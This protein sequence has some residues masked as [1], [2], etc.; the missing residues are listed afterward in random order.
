MFEKIVEFAKKPVVLLVSGTAVGSVVGYR[1]GKYFGKKAA[2]KK[3]E[4]SNVVVKPQQ[5]E[6]APGDGEQSGSTDKTKETPKEETT[7]EK[8]EE[9]KPSGEKKGK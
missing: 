8:K 2:L 1:V 9:K 7:A 6:Q 4:G 3:L 5:P